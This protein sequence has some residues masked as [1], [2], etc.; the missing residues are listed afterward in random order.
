MLGKLLIWVTLADSARTAAL[1]ESLRREGLFKKMSVNPNSVLMNGELSC[2]CFITTRTETREEA[3]VVVLAILRR[4]PI[5]Q[6]IKDPF[7]YDFHQPFCLFWVHAPLIAGAD[8][9]IEDWIGSEI[10]TMPRMHSSI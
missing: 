1:L 3:K 5:L 7:W 9:G 6:L 2:R 8:W 10:K 4:L